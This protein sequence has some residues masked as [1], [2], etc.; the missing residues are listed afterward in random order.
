MKEFLKYAAVLGGAVVFSFYLTGFFNPF[1]RYESHVSVSATAEEAWTIYSDTSTARDW[2]DGLS[3]LDLIAGNHNDTGA[4]Y[5]LE[6]VQDG[7]RLVLTQKIT[8]WEPP[9]LVRY[10]VENDIL[11]NDM[12]VDFVPVDSS[13]SNIR[14]RN[15]VW[16]KTFFWR[17]VFTIFKFMLSDPQ[18]RDYDRLQRLI[19]SRI[20]HLNRGPL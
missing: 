7:D 9:V 16:G 19:E 11:V 18:Q 4:T 6:L 13:R 17:A 15:Q 12:M 14:V 8:H 1:V 2:L 20:H 5:R 3:A 10:K